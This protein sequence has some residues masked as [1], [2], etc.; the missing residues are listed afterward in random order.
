MRLPLPLFPALFLAALTGLSAPAMAAA[1]SCTKDIDGIRLCAPFKIGT[2]LQMGQMTKIVLRDGA[3]DQRNVLTYVDNTSDFDHLATP[4]DKLTAL[5]TVQKRVWTNTFKNHRL[6]DQG[7]QPIPGG[8]AIVTQ[9]TSKTWLGK[10]KGATWTFGT[11]ILCDRAVL[12]EL[13][14]KDGETD[15]DLWALAGD[16]ISYLRHTNYD[17]ENGCQ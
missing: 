11:A 12:F 4:S 8:H 3:K 15:A 17:T 10:Q 2:G 14:Q 5:H 13:S 1:E 6:D 7:Q 9:L 16:L